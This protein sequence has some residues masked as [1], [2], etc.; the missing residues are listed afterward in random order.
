MQKKDMVIGLQTRESI[1]KHAC[2]C[3]I[4]GKMHCAPIP[5]DDTTASRKLKLVHSDVCGSIKTSSFGKHVYFV[6]FIDDVTHHTNKS[7]CI[8]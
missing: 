1:E 4:L 6:T 8:L 5:K 2:D 3:C 7:G